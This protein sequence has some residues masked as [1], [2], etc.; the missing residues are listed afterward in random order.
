MSLTRLSNLISSTEGRFLYVD[1]NEFNA[2]DL[3][4]NRGNSPTRPF[5]TIQ[6]ALLEVARFSYVAG[7]DRGNDKYDQYLSLIHI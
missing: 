6:R 1:P 5:K 3:I 4:T 7:P 2:S